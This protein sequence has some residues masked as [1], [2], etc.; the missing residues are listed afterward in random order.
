MQRMFIPTD[1]F[2]SSA[3]PVD[4]KLSQQSFSAFNILLIEDEDQDAMLVKQNLHASDL[5]PYQLLRAAELGEGIDILKSSPE[6]NIVLLDLHLRDSRGLDTFARLQKAFPQ[7]P[8]IVMTGK[9]DSKAGIHAV[10]MGAQSFLEKD[11]LSPH[12]L[13]SSIRFAVARKKMF[14]RMEQAISSAR[15]ANWELDP[16][17]NEMKWSNFIYDLLKTNEEDTPLHHL[18]NFLACVHPDDVDKVQDTIFNVMGSGKTESV[19]LRL[20]ATDFKTVFVSFQAESELN[21]FDTR[22]VVVGLVQDLTDRKRM[23]SLKAEK[24]LADRTAKLRQDFL[25]RTSHEIR[26]PL[27]PI[28]LLTKLLLDT[29]IST[30][31]REYLEAIDAAGKT[32]L[33]VVND[34]LDLS[35]IEAGKID[36][37]AEPFRLD[38]VLRQVEDIM[39]SGATEKGLSLQ[40]LTDPLLPGLVVGDSVRLTQILLNLLSNAIKFTQEGS[41]QVEV[42]KVARTGDR[43][44]IY[45]AVKD[46]GIGIPEDQKTR[47]FDSFQQLHHDPLRR[48]GGTGLGLNIV[49]K[50][51]QLQGGDIHLETKEN[52]GSC[53]SFTL[54]Y[55][56]AQ[57]EDTDLVP[58]QRQLRLDGV[59]VLL[60]EDNPLNQ[61]VMKKLFLDWGGELVIASHGREAIE[62][63]REQAF[64]LILMDVQMPVLDGLE[65]TRYIRSEFPESRNNIPIIALTAN[66]F[67]GTDDECLLA[68]MNDFIS[69]PIE[70]AHLYQK[71][72]RYSGYRSQPLPESNPTDAAAPADG[73]NPSDLFMM[74]QIDLTYLQEVSNGDVDIIRMAIRKYLETTPVYLA[75]LQNQ[76]RANDLR[77]LSKAAHKLK[78]SLDFMG[79]K[80]LKQ[81]ALRVETSCRAEQHTDQIP[82]WVNAISQGIEESYGQLREALETL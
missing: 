29:S 63:L 39:K 53:F 13:E 58:S 36:F 79:L 2:P 70:I 44:Q 5:R 17:T 77:E 52:E 45:F 11:Y 8:V 54:E 20:I 59:R 65:A 18:T 55:A 34:I 41:I 66:A 81:L 3:Y 32:L 7:V 76:L 37:M 26:T 56:V 10:E 33:A 48:Q 46:T 22:Q 64:D 4:P 27:N 24:E 15:L 50:L 57:D 25:A 60:A 21:P 12:L 68:G 40:I 69:K 30:Q 73:D 72:V 62:K 75:N 71:I 61:L 31:Q 6:I 1:A 42:K 82:L 23:E 67:S 28:L 49:Q 14:R 47:I 35:K 19:D 16:L 78:S 51:V 9:M 43:A 80:D 38:Q 74:T